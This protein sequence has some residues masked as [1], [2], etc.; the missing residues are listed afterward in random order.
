MRS[1]TLQ[2]LDVNGSQAIDVTKIIMT[3]FFN[4]SVTEPLIRVNCG[5]HT[6]IS[7]ITTHDKKL[8]SQSVMF[9]Y[10]YNTLNNSAHMNHNM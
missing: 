7:F 3:V 9:L 2:V 1:A 4:L 8:V 10:T 6:G 5:S